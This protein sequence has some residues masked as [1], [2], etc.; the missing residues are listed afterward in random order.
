MVI[1]VFSLV[2]FLREVVRTILCRLQGLL[3]FK[4]LV[5]FIAILHCHKQLYFDF[6]E[7]FVLNVL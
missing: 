5:L 4:V 3:T 2:P 7:R 6:L 1:I